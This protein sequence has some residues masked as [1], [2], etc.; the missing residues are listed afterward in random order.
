MSGLLPKHTNVFYCFCLLCSLHIVDS[1]IKMF[2]KEERF[3]LKSLYKA[4]FCSVVEDLD[5]V[6]PTGKVIYNLHKR[7]EKSG[8]VSAPLVSELVSS[9]IR[10][11]TARNRQ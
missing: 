2:T 8:S 7:F 4:G 10:F 6:L 9:D 3:Y 5:T 1:D 11:L